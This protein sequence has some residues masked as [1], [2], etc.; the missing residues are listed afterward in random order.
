MNTQSMQSRARKIILLI[1]DRGCSVAKVFVI[2]N[3]PCIEFQSASPLEK[4]AIAPGTKAVDLVSKCSTVDLPAPTSKRCC[5]RRRLQVGLVGADKGKRCRSY[6][7][8]HKC[9]VGVNFV[10]P[11]K[12]RDGSLDGNL[13][14]IFESI[15]KIVD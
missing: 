10:R 11:Y 3:C 7:L 5:L 12:A 9:K 2:M 8:V 6:I 4:P 1:Y 13:V 14:D 15:G